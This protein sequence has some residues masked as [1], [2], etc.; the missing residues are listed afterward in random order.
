MKRDPSSREAAGEAIAA[1]MTLATE[2]LPLKGRLLRAW[3]DRLSKINPDELSPSF[4]KKFLAIQTT[5][6]KRGLAQDSVD[7]LTAKE[8]EVLADQIVYF[9][10]DL[11]ALTVSQSK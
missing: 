1:L 6:S 4:R 9:A 11:D 10:L 7:A 5:M 3:L 2:D 8:T